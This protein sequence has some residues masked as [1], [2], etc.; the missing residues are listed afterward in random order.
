[1]DT[2]TFTTQDYF[3]G[4]DGCPCCGSKP[5]YTTLKITYYSSPVLHYQC[6]S[7][8]TSIV[9]QGVTPL[10]ENVYRAIVETSELCN[11]LAGVTSGDD[12]I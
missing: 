8:L 3:F 7:K 4:T 9:A 10:G 1:M 12:V 11:S 5:T 6:G 2:L